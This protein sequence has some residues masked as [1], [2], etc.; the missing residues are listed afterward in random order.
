MKKASRG[1]SHN[2]PRCKADFT[3]Y[4]YIFTAIANLRGTFSA[5]Y[6]GLCGLKPVSNKLYSIHLSNVLL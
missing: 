4:F 2:M 1:N 6:A 3:E 5:N